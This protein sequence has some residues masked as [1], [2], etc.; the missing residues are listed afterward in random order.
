MLPKKH[1]H[2]SICGIKPTLTAEA[3]FEAKGFYCFIVHCC[4]TA[5]LYALFS[6]LF[7]IISN[8][9]DILDFGEN[10]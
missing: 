10:I 9:S 4:T 5:S 3:D 2:S 8:V 1:S 6:I 7:T